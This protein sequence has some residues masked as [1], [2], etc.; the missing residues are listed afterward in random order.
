MLIS[1][2][3]F[4]IPRR[5][6]CSITLHHYVELFPLSETDVGRH[7]VDWLPVA[8]KNFFM[9]TNV[10]FWQ[11]HSLTAHKKETNVVATNQ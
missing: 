7:K 3:N 1:Y 9:A 10:P 6:V 5:S 8:T 4:L 2:H 11:P